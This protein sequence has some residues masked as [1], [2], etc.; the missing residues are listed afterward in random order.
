MTNMTKIKLLL[1]A[2]LFMAIPKSLWAYT[3]DQI[4]TFD[5]GQTHYKVLVPKGSNA[6]LMFI[7]TKKSGKLVIPAE[8][9]DGQ[10]I[11]FKVTTVGYQANYDCSQVTS[12]ELPE[13]IVEMKNDCFKNAILTDMNIPKSL[14]EIREDAWSAIKEV[15]KFTVAEGHTVFVADDKGVLYTTGKKE[16]RCVPSKIMEAVVGDTYTIDNSVEKICINAF[17]NVADLKKIVIPKDLQE[18]TEKY[19]SI[20]P[21]GTELVEFLM[22]EVGNTNFKV[23]DGVLFN[24]KTHT[25]VCYPREIPTTAYTLPDDIKRI[26]PF[27]MMMVKHMTSLDLNN[28]EKMEISALY[29]PVKLESITIPAN[30]KK[31]GLIDGAFEECLK[32]KEYKVEEGNPDFASM[33]GVLFSSDKTKLCYYPL[34]KDENSYTIP[35][36]VTELSKKAFQG[37]NKLTSMIIPSNVKIIGNEAFRNMTGLETVTFENPSQVTELKADVFRAC[38]KLKEV[39]LPASITTIASA[40]YECKAL[41][42]ITIPNGSKLKTIEA[43]AFATNTKLKNFIFEGSCELET[44]NF[45]AFANAKELESFNFPKSIKNIELNAFNGCDKMTTVTFHPEADIEKIGAG[46]FA[47]CGLNA[48]S[49]PKKVKVIEREAFSSCKALTEINIEQYTTTI[50]PEAFKFCENLTDINIHKENTKYSSL[51]GYLLTHDKKTLVLFPPG[52]ANNKFTLL[53]PSIEK[54]GDYSF[55]NCEKLTNVAI[56]N[57]VKEIGIRAFGL[58][59]KLKTITFLCDEMIDPAKINQA[60]NEMSFDDGSQTN[61]ESM[62][63][64]ITINV[65]EALHSQYDNTDFYKKFKG[66]IKA[67]FK[68]KTEE[69]IPMSDNIVNMLSTERQDHTFVLPT[70]IEHDGKHYDVKL[71]GDYAFEGASDNI[72]EVVVRNNVEYIGA[73]AFITGKDKNNPQSTIQNVFFIESNPTEKMLS[74][75]RFEL[76]ET[77][78]NYNE[79]AKATK[80][81]VKK[82]ALPIYQDKWNKKVYD[83]NLHG[84]TVSPFNFINQIDYKIPGV[85]ISKKYGTFA[86]EFDVDFSVYKTDKGSCDVGAF[87]SKNSDVKEGK[88][89]YGISKYHVKMKSVDENGGASGKYGYVPK[90]TGVLLKVLDKEATPQ[91]FY[92][93]IGELD[94][95]SYNITDNIMKGITVNSASVS[96][97]A[98]DPIYVMQG[99]IFKKVTS[100]IE[101]FPIH[102]AYAKIDGVPAGANLSFDFSDDDETTGITTTEAEN[103]TDDVYYNLNGQRVTNPQNGVFIHRGRKVIIK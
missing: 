49:L 24:K 56:P 78:D 33:E 61:G 26:C 5:N 4:V 66:G 54:I 28:V 97:S 51:N 21:P 65:R 40:F 39:M 7:G 70:S 15:P 98:T 18:V 91:D 8:I 69:F 101:V 79:F 85:T 63:D 103:T 37:A 76:D 48:I 77:G 29:K 1:L 71:I 52:K 59:K 16:L 35:A 46:A 86:R 32:L 53:P 42:K 95:T 45:N 90:Y 58:C 83:L 94:N 55:Y 92:Y 36:T 74:T 14:T 47:N 96:A 12:V 27:A 100:T 67:S 44:I 10:G 88:G 102:K 19:P 84:E 81:Y 9:N 57:K 99:G 89:D 23:V 64:N 3:T 25:L 34:A 82:T 31:E 17:R 73:K 72:K 87:V 38:D 75:T 43:S 93:A 68:V 13:G 6:A 22:P 30:L 62:F 2:L 11:T 60:K 41:E 80:V 50:H 20:V